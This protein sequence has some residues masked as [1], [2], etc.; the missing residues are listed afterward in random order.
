MHPSGWGCILLTEKSQVSDYFEMS[1]DLAMKEAI[2]I[3]KALYAFPTYVE[4]SHVNVLVDN[5]A[6]INGWHNQG[7]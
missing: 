4:N 5:Q 2:V 3:Y 7:G 6:V 1:W